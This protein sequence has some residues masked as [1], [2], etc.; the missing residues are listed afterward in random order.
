MLSKKYGLLLLR[1]VIIRIAQRS[2]AET[3]KFFIINPEKGTKV[4]TRVEM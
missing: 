2:T 3:M 4:E 1:K